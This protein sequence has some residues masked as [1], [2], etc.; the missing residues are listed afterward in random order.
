MKICRFGSNL[1]SQYGI[2]KEGS[3]YQLRGDLYSDDREPGDLV[4]K[5]SEVQL[6]PPAQPSKI[7][8]IGRN[9]L[10]HAEEFGRET[11]TEPILFFKP[12]S[13]L[14][15]HKSPIILLPENGRVDHE[16]EVAV[17]IGK[18]GRFIPEEE[19]L[20]YILGYTCANDVSDRTFQNNDKQWT[21]AKGFDSFCPLG[22]WLETDLDISDLKI[23][24]LLNGEEKQSSTTSLMLFSVQYLITYISRIMTLFPGDLILTGTPAG[25]GP[26]HPGDEIEICVEGIGSLINPVL[27][28]DI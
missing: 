18:E 4:G 15:G 11:P 2:L 19:A 1:D 28:A 9:Y 23:Q 6:L 10:A 17:V 12:P 7:I 13:S 20:S 3:I 22:P 5:I 25:V 24:C 21:R 14:I 26:I 8:C 16:S 27:L